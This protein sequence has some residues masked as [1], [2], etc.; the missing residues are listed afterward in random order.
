MTV[1]VPAFETTL[2]R[3][4]VKN[5][6]FD[7]GSDGVGIF[8][9][10]GGADQIINSTIMNNEVGVSS[11]G[12]SPGEGVTITDD[13][14]ITGNTIALRAGDSGSG[15]G[16]ITISDSTLAANGTICQGYLWSEVTGGPL[17]P[18]EP[19]LR[20]QDFGGNDVPN[21]DGDLAF[22]P[23]DPC[24]TIPTYWGWLIPDGDGDCDGFTDAVE[25]FVGTDPNDPCA[26]T[27]TKDDEDDDRWP[28]DTNDDQFVNT[29]DL[30]PYIGSPPYEKRLDLNMD[31]SL[32]SDD[33]AEFSPFL[34]E[35][36][37]P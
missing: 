36:C 3:V 19:S 13:R 28:V 21:T 5:H 25:D 32:N 11:R 34:N 1:R 23:C 29:F 14:T 27:A 2:R 37:L 24:P 7:G 8:F 4:T 30:L 16:F 26:N 31:G 17:P 20:I 35:P 12:S 6:V 22:D 18:G 33:F 10:A 9:E 15:A